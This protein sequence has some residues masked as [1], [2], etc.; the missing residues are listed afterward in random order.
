M[1]YYA[2]RLGAEVLKAALIA[3]MGVLL[4]ELASTLNQ[5]IEDDQEDWR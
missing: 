2:K 5:R 3:I 4:K 1:T